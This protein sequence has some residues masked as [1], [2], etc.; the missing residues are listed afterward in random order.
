[1][2]RSRVGII[3][4]G[5]VALPILAAVAVLLP[6]PGWF[7]EEFYSRGV[8]PWLQLGVTTVSNL[9]PIAVLDVLIATAVGLCLFRAVQFVRSA[10]SDGLRALWEVVRR[11]LR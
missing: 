1:M 4:R 5:W 6:V 9:V 7:V 8:Y 10:M 11:L 3:V 2:A